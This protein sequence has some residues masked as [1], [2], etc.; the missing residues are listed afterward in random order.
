MK[1][2]S[3][4]RILVILFYFTLSFIH[5]QP[6]PGDIFRDYV[7][8][9]PEESPYKFLR[10]TGDG[11][12]REPVNHE[13][14]YPKE[15]FTDGWLKFPYVIDLNDAVRAEIQVE[16]LLSHDGT[17]GLS[18][19][20]NTSAWLE[21]PESP[22]IPEPQYDYL[23]HNFPVVNVPLEF[24]KEEGNRLRF[25]V[26]SVQR[27]GMPQNILY[28]IHLRIYYDENKLH[29]VAEMDDISNGDKLD[30]SV[31]FK[32][33]NIS[34]KIE[35]V[36][37]VGYY[38]DVNYEG[39]GNYLQWHYTFLRGEMQQ[40]IGHSETAPFAVTWNTEWIPDQQKPFKAGAVLQGENGIC[41]FINPVDDLSFD[42]DYTVE[43]CKPFNQPK[44]WATREKE[45]EENFQLSG[46]PSVVAEF[47]LVFTSWSPGYLNG[48]YLNDWLVFIKE[49]CHYCPGFHRITMDIP[50]MLNQAVN[51]VQ[52]GKT[53]LVNGKM[54]HGTEI[55]YP[56]I[57]VL[58][59]YP[60]TVL[61]E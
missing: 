56:G 50:F 31:D 7:W 45:F 59:K 34:G 40:Q 2:T 36:D 3:R 11:D 25:K 53:P 17:R 12:Y 47:Q 9:T 5:A 26:D 16:K 43:L 38:E 23:Y 37:Y 27:F 39:D 54:V 51:T 19:K 22:S 52:T 6:K 60:K 57:M 44:M 33:K 10:V 28:G 30:E 48:I 32:L 13:D 20:V 1:L 24:I 58:V 8:T 41:Y 46:N 49:G 21:F 14:V 61:L 55:L 18:V 15:F 42:R 4:K 29:P 35:K